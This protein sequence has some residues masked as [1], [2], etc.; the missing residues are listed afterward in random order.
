MDD[1]ARREPVWSSREWRDEYKTNAQYQKKEE[2]IPP[3]ITT[4]RKYK[5]LGREK[6]TAFTRTHTHDVVDETRTTEKRQRTVAA[7]VRVS[8]ALLIQHTLCSFRVFT[9][10]S[11][12]LHQ[13]SHLVDCLL[14]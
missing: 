2:L 7:P 5:E 6:R 8:S 14:R 1:G 10:S 3:A 13:A 9:P 4:T 11:V 12:L